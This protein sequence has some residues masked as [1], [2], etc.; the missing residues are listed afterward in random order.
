MINIYKETERYI[1]AK[2][3]VKRT[4]RKQFIHASKICLQKSKGVLSSDRFLHRGSLVDAK[5]LYK[6]IDFHS[7]YWR[8]ALSSG[9]V[10]SLL[11]VFS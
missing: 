11:A 6:G 1:N 3:A 10:L 5:R 8:F 7:H 9:S 2:T 4:V